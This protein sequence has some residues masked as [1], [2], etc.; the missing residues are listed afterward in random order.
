MRLKNI[1]PI[2][3][4]AWLIF[5]VCAQFTMVYFSRQ[6]FEGPDQVDYYKLGLDYNRERQRQE[7]QH[8]LGWK[9]AV[10][11][12]EQIH[13][14]QPFDLRVG[15]SD[16]QGRQLEGELFVLLRQPVT[17]RFDRKVPLV[18]KGSSYTSQITLAPGVWD[19]N[20]E[21]R[22]ASFRYLHTRRVFVL[23]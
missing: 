10:A 12:P 21:F 14:G 22:C 6:G 13:G 8:K 16:R 5:F 9:L 1:W 4:A 11:L 7:A 20:F 23:Q 18:R 3:L 2:G 15:A 19:L 17:K